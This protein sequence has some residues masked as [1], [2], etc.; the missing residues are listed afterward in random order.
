MGRSMV[1]NV[2][3]AA[4]MGYLTLPPGILLPLRE[5]RQLPPEEVVLLTTGSQG[6]PTS[7]LVRIANG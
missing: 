1:D 6:E 7:A 5:T 4:D 3:M 2:N